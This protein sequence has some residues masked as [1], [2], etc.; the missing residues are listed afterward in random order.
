MHNWT[1]FAAARAQAT[2]AALFLA[3]STARADQI[4]YEY[5]FVTPL[6][7]SGDPGSLGNVSFATTAGSHVSTA[8]TTVTAATL[9]AV[10]S[11]PASAPDKFSGETYNL[12]LQLSDDASGKSGTLTFN[13]K[14]F[15]TLS[16]Q[17]ANITSSFT[18]ATQTLVLGNDKYTVNL[19]PFALNSTTTMVG[20]LQA[21]IDVSPGVASTGP[22]TQIADAPEPSTLL[23][24]GLGGL[25]AAVAWRR[26]RLAAVPMRQNS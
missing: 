25:A 14:L 12:T 1:W 6:A 3:A 5:N 7:V 17:S 19:G 15:G 18:S 10:S 21:T 11:A 26:P 24:A 13:G 20:T 2:L 9:A 8:A 4:G 16:A 23:L 22:S